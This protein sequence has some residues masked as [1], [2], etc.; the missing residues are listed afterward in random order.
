MIFAEREQDKNAHE[1]RVQILGVDLGF[2][3]TKF[4]V[5]GLQALHLYPKA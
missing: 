1:A 2:K 5:R 4:T 3:L